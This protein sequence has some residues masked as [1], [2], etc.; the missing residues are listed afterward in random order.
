MLLDLGNLLAIEQPE[1]IPESGIPHQKFKARA[2]AEQI[3]GDDDRW[4]D[5]RLGVAPMIYDFFPFIHN[6]E[7]YGAIARLVERVLV[8]SIHSDMAQGYSR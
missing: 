3:V 4:N 5:P 2:A 6:T 7:L 8:A 1:Q